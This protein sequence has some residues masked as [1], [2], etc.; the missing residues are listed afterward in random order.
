MGNISHD[1]NTCFEFVYIENRKIEKSN[2]KKRKSTNWKLEKSKNEHRTTR[3]TEKSNC[4]DH[5]EETFLWNWLL[6][7]QLLVSRIKSKFDAM[8]VFTTFIFAAKK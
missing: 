3:K 8:N 6:Y 4:R 5:S 2:I 1:K 7:P